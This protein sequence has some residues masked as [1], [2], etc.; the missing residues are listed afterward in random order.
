MVTLQEIK[1]QIAKYLYL[2]DTDVVDVILATV[3]ANRIPGDSI[4]LYLIG[5]SSSAKTELLNCLT[6]YPHIESVSKITPHTLVSG[7]QEKGKKSEDHSLLTKLQREGRNILVLKDFTT[8]I[9]MRRE[10]R[11]ELMSQFREMAD[12]RFTAHYGMGQCI[13]LK[14]KFGVIA[15]CTTAIDEFSSG[16]AMLGERFLK[17]RISPEDAIMVARIGMDINLDK[18]IVRD[19]TSKMVKIFLE[20]FECIFETLPPIDPELVRKV[21]ALCIFGAHLRSPIVRDEKGIQVSEVDHEGPGRLI[22]ST[23]KLII[24]LAL[25]RGLGIA[26]NSLL[27]LVKK[28]IKDTMPPYRLLAARA[29]YISHG[30][31]MSLTDIMVS[32]NVSRSTASAHCNDLVS[33]NIASRETVP[34]V[35]TFYALRETYV[36]LIEDSQIFIIDKA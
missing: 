36:R 32:M 28:L 9:S 13:I 22:T 16:N 24:S 20:Q 27:P 25:V 1:D 21:I 19:E 15:A 33:L 18:D 8:I 4:S 34:K 14:M 26:D 11:G 2:T 35:N 23:R 29:L 17:Y 31:P 3:I 12:G 7:Y 10:D 5:P 30:K 6:E